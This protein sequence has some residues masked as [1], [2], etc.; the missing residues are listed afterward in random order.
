MLSACSKSLPQVSLSP[1]DLNKQVATA[2]EQ[3]GRSYLHTSAAEWW[4]KEPAHKK[5][6]GGW[7]LY[8]TAGERCGVM[9][10]KKTQ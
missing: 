6:R 7:D 2:V 1:G 5:N 10:E 8:F 3:E 9:P 4:C